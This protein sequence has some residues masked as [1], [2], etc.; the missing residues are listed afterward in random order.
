MNKEFWIQT[1]VN[2]IISGILISAAGKWFDYKLSL[3]LED[4]KP[5]TAATILKQ[6][7]FLNAKKEAIHEAV[8]LLVKFVAASKWSGP[9]VPQKRK[10]TAKNLSEIDKNTVYM[11]LCL[12]VDN[13]EIP[14]KFIEVMKGEN[15]NPV[16]LG[17]LIT[18]FRNDLGYA[19]GPVTPE[20]FKVILNK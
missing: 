11:K 1:F 14:L 17:E 10:P 12:Y 3:K 18:L 13:P 6:E 4:Y 19:N 20:D 5:L 9:D 7:N 2:V 16:L 15:V 8:D